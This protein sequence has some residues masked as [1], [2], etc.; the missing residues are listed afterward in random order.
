MARPTNASSTGDTRERILREAA[1]LFSELGFQGASTRAI[2]EA[3]GIRQPSL[4]HYFAGKEAIGH[5]L[6]VA[7]VS[8]SPLLSG[9]FARSADDPAVDLFRLFR[10]EMAIELGGEF[11]T[12]WL[13]RLP[14]ALGEKFPAWGA[15]VD[16]ARATMDAVLRDGIAAGQFIAE[17]PDAVLELFDAVANEAMFWPHDTPDVPP[18]TIAKVQLRLVISDPQTIAEVVARAGG[19]SGGPARGSGSPD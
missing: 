11:D 10:D 3:V 5:E 15:A 18:E 12:R 19:M 17:D 9:G 6:I 4:F 8:A 1:R 7:R 16:V 13:F 2:T 14:P